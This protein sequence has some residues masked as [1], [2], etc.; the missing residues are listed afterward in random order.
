MLNVL[1]FQIALGSELGMFFE[2]KVGFEEV[3]GM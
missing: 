3:L 1:Y 2:A